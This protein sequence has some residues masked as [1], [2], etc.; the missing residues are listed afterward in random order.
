MSLGAVFVRARDGAL[1]REPIWVFAEGFIC[2]DEDE[3]PELVLWIDPAEEEPPLAALLTLSGKRLVAAHTVLRRVFGFGPAGD[4]CSA[5]V[6]SLAPQSDAQR[7]FPGSDPPDL[8]PARS[9]FFEV[10]GRPPRPT[11]DDGTER[12]PR[13]AGGTVFDW[14]ATAL[15]A[16]ALEIPE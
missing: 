10:V 5:D 12:Y 11:L 3:P 4:A 7:V 9:F 13:R 6:D 15:D 8:K 14:P 16:K 1:Y 2:F